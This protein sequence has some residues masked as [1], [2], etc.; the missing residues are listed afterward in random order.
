MLNN[1]GAFGKPCLLHLNNSITAVCTNKSC[2]NRVLCFECYEAHDHSHKA[3]LIPI[4]D[5]LKFK[6]NKELIAI[7]KLSENCDKLRNSR[8][9]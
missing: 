7:G 4:L 3:Q 9:L 5:V 1:L 2:K 8:I 6:I